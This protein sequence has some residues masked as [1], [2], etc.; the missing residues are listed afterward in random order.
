MK[1]FTLYLKIFTFL[2]LIWIFP[3]FYK[4]D[5]SKSLI[6]RD[7]LQTRIGLKHERMLAEDDISEEKSYY[8]KKR[9]EHYPSGE[10]EMILH[11]L[12]HLMDIYFTCY[13]ANIKS[14]FEIEVFLK[15]ENEMRNKCRDKILNTYRNNISWSNVLPEV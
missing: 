7:T 1:T 14:D 4:Y 13:N 8:I 6:N 3:S 10:E 9:V 11:E 5:S 12:F 2:L 15:K